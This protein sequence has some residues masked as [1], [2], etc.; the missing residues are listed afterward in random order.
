M[1]RI[2]AYIAGV[3]TVLVVAVSGLGVAALASPR[4][5]PAVFAYAASSVTEISEQFGVRVTYFAVS[6]CGDT[7]HVYGCYDPATPDLIY[8]SAT[9]DDPE[10]E[11]WVV[12]HEIGH[13]LHDRMGSVSSE[14]SADMFARSMLGTPPSEADWHC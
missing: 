13:A 11:R 14:C 1:N 12:L 7:T 9:I 2:T 10:L 6:P 3:V 5:D 4:V 8:V